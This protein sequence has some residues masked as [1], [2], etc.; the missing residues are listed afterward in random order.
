[1]KRRLRS[2][3]GENREREL[4]GGPTTTRVDSIVGGGG[5]PLGGTRPPPRAQRPVQ[6]RLA[7]PRQSQGPCPTARN[8]T[9]RYTERCTLSGV[10]RARCTQ[11]TVHRALYTRETVHSKGGAARGL[12][13]REK[14]RRFGVSLLF[15][16]ETV[17]SKGDRSRW[18][19][20]LGRKRLGPWER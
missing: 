8:D 19:R 18:P 2:G 16:L 10:H 7:Q 11:S 4:P 12:G 3:R 5:D 17:H 20:S 13:P 15:P 6:T 1:M 14:I 9:I